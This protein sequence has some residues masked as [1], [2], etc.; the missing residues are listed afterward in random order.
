MLSI[1]EGYFCIYFALKKTVFQ[2]FF[3]YNFFVNFSKITRYVFLL[4]LNINTILLPLFHKSEVN[5]KLYDIPYNLQNHPLI[6]G[7]YFLPVTL[8]HL[9]KSQAHFLVKITHTNVKL[10]S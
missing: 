2:L 9:L 10:L 3:H 4:L 1:A 5:Q 7:L 8:L 6:D